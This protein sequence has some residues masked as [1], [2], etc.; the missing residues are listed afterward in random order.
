LFSMF[1]AYYILWFR[2]SRGQSMHLLVSLFF[3]Q[4]PLAFES[5]TTR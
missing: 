5:S 1:F 4:T 2:H 3:L